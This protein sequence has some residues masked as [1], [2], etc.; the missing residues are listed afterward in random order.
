MN[1]SGCN[2]AL[3]L[4]L[5]SILALAACTDEPDKAVSEMP[6]GFLDEAPPPPVSATEILSGGTLVLPDGTQINDSIIIITNGNLVAWGRRGSVDVPNDSVGHD[7]RGKW[8]VPTGLT[9]GAPAEL[10]FSELP[11]GAT[12]VSHDYIGGYEAGLLDLPESD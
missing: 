8:V 2:R 1:Y 9:T 12:E 11:R 5:A 3:A 6:P 4:I 10:R 7:L